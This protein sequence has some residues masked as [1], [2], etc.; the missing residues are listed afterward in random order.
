MLLLVHYSIL[1][2]EEKTNK[3]FKKDLAKLKKTM[4]NYM[5]VL[6]VLSFAA[7]ALTI[8]QWFGIIPNQ[9]GRAVLTIIGLG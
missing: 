2:D 8:L 7:A 9:F 3:M 5:W 4:K 6:Y 1:R